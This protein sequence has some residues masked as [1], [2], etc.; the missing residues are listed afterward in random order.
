[1]HRLLYAAALLLVASVVYA[2]AA[3]PPATAP[4]RIDDRPK[5]QDVQP[6]A[7]QPV[8]GLR[9]DVPRRLIEIDGRI[10]LREGWLELF[11]CTPNTKEHESIVVVDVKPRLIHF[12]LLT[13]GAQPGK[14]LE[15]QRRGDELVPIPA[16]GDRIQIDCVYE[17]DGVTKTVPAN[18]WVFNRATNKV[19]EN[20]IWV[21]AGSK[22]RHFDGHPVYMA[23][24]EGAAVSLVNFGSDLLAKPNRFTDSNEDHGEAWVAHT[25]VLPEVGTPVTLRLRLVE[26]PD[27]PEALGD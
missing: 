26:D 17:A 19:M 2:Q 5:P 3:S 8:E 27:A 24:L 15:L 21:F 16:S 18:Q 1:M 14:P 12:A 22:L 9:I 13:I 6:P 4:D 7:T 25:K 10:A 11:A 23:D 20:N